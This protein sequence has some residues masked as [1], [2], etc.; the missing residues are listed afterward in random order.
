MVNNDDDDNVT[1]QE[2][3]DNG[4]LPNTKFE[5]CLSLALL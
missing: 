5:K 4:D 3:A 1:E 2:C